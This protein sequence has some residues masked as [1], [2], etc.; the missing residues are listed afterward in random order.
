MPRYVPAARGRRAGGSWPHGL[1]VPA[2]SMVRR[3]L[4]PPSVAPRHFNTPAQ[5]PVG[6]YGF[7][8]G[9]ISAGG[10]A[11][12]HVGPSGFNTSWKLAQASVTTTTGPADTAACSFYAQPY[13]TPAQ[14]WQVGQSYQAGGDQ[15]GLSGVK[16]VTGEYLFAVWSGGHPGDICTLILTGVM[17]VLS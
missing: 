12:L 5:V 3:P 6:P 13:G 14:P 8:Q 1:V 11:I 10:A 7:A 17:T 4:L 15:V 2:G 16:L 9:I